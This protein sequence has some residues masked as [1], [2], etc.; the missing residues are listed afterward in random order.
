MSHAL[1]QSAHE[2]NEQA[3]TEA[4]AIA[5]GHAGHHKDIPQYEHEPE[6]TPLPAGQGT[7]GEHHT[8]HHHERIY[9]MLVSVLRA[10]FGAAP[11]R[12]RSELAHS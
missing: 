6:E 2:T 7:Q 9:N 3:E 4:E 12:R 8:R 10:G 11:A 1:W 5:L